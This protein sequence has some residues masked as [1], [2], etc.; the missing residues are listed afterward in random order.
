MIQNL[1]QNERDIFK[2]MLWKWIC[3]LSMTKLE[4]LSKNKS[5]KHYDGITPKLYFHYYAENYCINKYIDHQSVTDLNH[6][7][8]VEQKEDRYV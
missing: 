3:N 2:K 1:L 7:N 5:L 8:N 6:D 4:D